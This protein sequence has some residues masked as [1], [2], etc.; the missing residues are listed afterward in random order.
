MDE[1][2]EGVRQ[3]RE[4]NTYNLFYSAVTE[5]A[6]PALYNHGVRIPMF[7]PEISNPRTGVTAE[8]D[9][10]LYDGETCVLAEIKS[11]NN[12]D[13]RDIR[14]MR[15]CA[16]ID[17]EAAEKALRAAQV[18]DRIGLSGTVT[19]VEPIIMYQDMDEEYLEEVREEYTQFADTV[20]ELTNHAVLM[21]QD[22]GGELRPLAGEFNDSGNLQSLLRR[23]IELP[24]NPPDQLMLT[25]GM[26]HE[27]LAMA[28]ADVWGEQA[29]DHD[30]GIE[31]SRTEVRD[32]FAPKH[33]VGLTELELVF[34]FLV[35][36]GA[37]EQVE[38]HTYRFTRDHM[39][40][41]LAVEQQVLS[42]TVQDY[43]HG[44]EQASLTDSFDGN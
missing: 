31:V 43:L 25:E 16:S 29:L 5:R 22:Y 33:N 40:A 2:T 35:E 7:F 42:E 27:V 4:V 14:Q 32:Y 24:E 26:E 8:P 41:V 34:E 37:C 10:V 9:F 36:F 17:I 20:D 11:G 39:D 1:V 38:N 44:S 6:T 28:V 13:G 30:D 3:R 15:E 12:I 23:G 21:T 18:R 19:A